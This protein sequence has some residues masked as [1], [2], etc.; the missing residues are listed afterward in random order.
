MKVADAL[1]FTITKL[2][3]VC[4]RTQYVTLVVFPHIN[5]SVL[6]A[7]SLSRHGGLLPGVHS[8]RVSV[9]GPENWGQPES[10]LPSSA[11]VSWDA[12]SR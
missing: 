7:D 3:S 11:L 8:A 12:S 5:D 10:E 6:E 4:N 9:A 2:Y 1:G